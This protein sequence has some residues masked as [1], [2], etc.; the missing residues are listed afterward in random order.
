MCHGL[1]SLEC[2][3]LVRG[4]A[5]SRPPADLSGGGHPANWRQA[6]SEAFQRGG[7]EAR[8]HATADGMAPKGSPRWWTHPWE[9]EEADLGDMRSATADDLG[10]EV[11]ADGVTAEGELTGEQ[12][13]VQPDSLV[14]VE[15]DA[16]SVKVEADAGVTKEAAADVSAEAEQA[17]VLEVT[18]EEP[19]PAPAASD[20]ATAEEAEKAAAAAAEAEGK[21]LAPFELSAEEARVA[22]KPD[23]ASVERLSRVLEHAEEKR[24]DEEEVA[25]AAKETPS[26]ASPT[27]KLPSGGL[28][29]K[30][31]VVAMFD[32]MEPGKRLPIDRLLKMQVAA[33]R[34]EVR[35]A[36]PA[37]AG[38]T[39]SAQSAEPAADVVEGGASTEPDDR[40]L[41]IGSDFAM[42][43]VSGTGA[44]AR[45]VAWLGR[46]EKLRCKV[47]RG[48]K[49]Q[50]EPID[51]D[52]MFGHGY[53]VLG[54][55][56]SK[57]PV[58]GEY[59]HGKTQDDKFYP[60]DHFLGLVR[61]DYVVTSGGYLL[62]NAVDQLAAIA[63][64]IKRTEPIKP[65]S[66]RTHG[67]QADADERRR[68]RQSD[69][70][71]KPKPAAPTDQHKDRERE[72][73]ER[74]ARRDEAKATQA[75]ADEGKRARGKAAKA[76]RAAEVAT[77][78]IGEAL[79]KAAA[80]TAASAA[81]VAA[82]AEVAAVA[83]AAAAASAA[84]AA[85]EI[86]TATAAASAAE[87][88]SDV[89][90]SWRRLSNKWR[91]NSCWV[92]AALTLWETMQRWL[93][94]SRDQ[95]SE[96][97]VP[98]LQLPADCTLKFGAGAK[99]SVVS[100]LG[101]A[102]REWWRLRVA[103]IAA[104]EGE[105]DVAALT[106]RLMAARDAVRLAF[107]QRTSSSL[108][109]K[110]TEA[111]LKKEL[112]AEMERMGGTVSALEAF[113]QP[114]RTSFL[115][116]GSTPKC[117]PCGK[118]LRS[119][120]DL[121]SYATSIV[122]SAA[123]LT[124]AEGDCFAALEAKVNQPGKQKR[125]RACPHCKQR[126]RFLEQPH[127]SVVADGA[128]TLLLLELPADPPAG[129]PYDLR[130][131][132]APRP[133]VIGGA[134][135]GSYRLVGMLMYA[136]GYHFFADVID[137]RERRWLRYDGMVA[138]GVGQPVVPTGGA[139]MHDD[140][141]YYPTLAVYVREGGS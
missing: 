42:A 94:I 104:T 18:E 51:P 19:P 105:L 84:V 56:Y 41:R 58:L 23:A 72:L 95:S 91:G 60:L 50:K 76:A 83:A 123:E 109:L 36:K 102:L 31:S 86:E 138:G 70:H 101:Q 124:D 57:T 111:A 2:A 34:T 33:K 59:I 52:D 45:R 135:Q 65:G 21:G 39:P 77:P 122:L 103:E 85:A 87:V 69:D 16:D 54:S 125:Q 107:L 93:L 92:D 89:L 48:S 44:A 68:E 98:P 30:S 27:L 88:P 55:W 63:A 136:K 64:G 14:K 10:D 29:Y 127:T 132:A 79:K 9:A 74:E 118:L 117:A 3:T 17:D 119:P 80:V 1:K 130:P 96:L 82:A 67:D 5:E 6:Y 43:F 71:L 32:K 12:S 25:A 46:V 4:S 134:V 35:E 13:T 99:L 20:E 108:S 37:S 49:P 38:V 100:N 73:R 11:L 131:S 128:P 137:P 53:E 40:L 90:L 121:A 8:R 106:Q 140:H 61:L 113:T 112:Q 22:A 78:K 28:G 116:A 133:L 114:A 110:R 115:R 141:R 81:A 139:T 129:L 7:D 126:S 15:D 47:G 120:S 62:D 75:A 97:P 26:R 24:Q 66:A